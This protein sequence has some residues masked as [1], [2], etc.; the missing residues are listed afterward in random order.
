M[1]NFATSSHGLDRADLKILAIIQT[2]NQLSHA[3]IGERVGLSTS[4]VR[5]RIRAMENNGTIV[6]N[7]ALLDPEFF[8]VTLIVELA[9]TTETKESYRNLDALIASSAY[10]QQS[11]HVAGDIDYVLIVHG[12]SLRWY[13]EWVG[14]HFT[15]DPNIRRVNTR[16]VWSRRKFKPAISV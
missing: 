10:I 3:E 2:N 14:E 15:D 11:Y 9:F 12:P 5:R 1:N 8:G 6:G 4:A 7:I 16:V 13:E